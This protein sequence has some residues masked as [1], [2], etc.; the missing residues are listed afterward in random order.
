MF[1]PRAADEGQPETTL[2]SA[3]L[4]DE[5]EEGRRKR[6]EPNVEWQCIVARSL[7]FIKLSGW[8][9]AGETVNRRDTNFAGLILRSDVSQRNTAS[10]GYPISDP[11]L[12]SL[13]ANRCHATSTN[14]IEVLRGNRPKTGRL[15][16]SEAR[17]NRAT[18]NLPKKSSGDWKG[19]R[20]KRSVLV[21]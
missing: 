4:T 10:D 18:K 3:R 17:L 19:A 21:G 15:P 9:G 13:Y 6:A 11:V 16:N 12:F 5:R 14:V 2:A 8:K 7:V 1:L 20:Q